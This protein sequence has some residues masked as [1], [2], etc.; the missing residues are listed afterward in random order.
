MQQ[1]L[2]PRHHVRWLPWPWLQTSN[3]TYLVSVVRG[4]NT[5]AQ[6]L[7]CMFF[8]SSA[9]CDE[10]ASFDQ[11]VGSIDVEKNVSDKEAQPSMLVHLCLAVPEG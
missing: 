2:R 6:P 7:A 4:M 3:K 5:K 8:T 1:K 11:A 9:A 10:L